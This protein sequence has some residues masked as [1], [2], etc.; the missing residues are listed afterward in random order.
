M[1]AQATNRFEREFNS[2]PAHVQRALEKQVGF[3]L[4]DL[5]YPSLRAKKHDEA[6]DIWQARATGSWRFYIRIDGDTYLLLTI[7]S[8]PK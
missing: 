4:R 2:A 7:R 1:R 6:R 5:R 8:H 3:L